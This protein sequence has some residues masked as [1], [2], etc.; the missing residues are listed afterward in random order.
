MAF[1]IYIIVQ[2]AMI[3]HWRKQ[4]LNEIHDNEVWPYGPVDPQGWDRFVIK[5]GVPP[6]AVRLQ[7]AS[8]SLIDFVRFEEGL[9]VA[10][11]KAMCP[12]ALNHFEK[13]RRPVLHRFGE[14]LKQI[15]F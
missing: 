15:T 5:R 12:F 6:K 11:P 14:N 9:E 4:S 13:E 3:V 7:I 8:S 2:L 10:L 1:G